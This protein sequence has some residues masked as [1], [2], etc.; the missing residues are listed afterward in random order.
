MHPIAP[1]PPEN[2]GGSFFGPFHAATWKDILAG[3]SVGAMLGLM[4]FCLSYEV[5]FR[6]RQYA[7]GR[8]MGY[9]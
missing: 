8:R 2:P 9:E 6:W 5:V 4:A 7:R 1:P 3:L